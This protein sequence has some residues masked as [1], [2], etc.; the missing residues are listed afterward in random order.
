MTTPPEFSGGGDPVLRIAGILAERK[1]VEG[2]YSR[3]AEAITTAA[4]K[5]QGRGP[6]K[7]AI[8]DRR[9]LKKIVDHHPKV[10]L[11]YRELVA[12]DNYL[13][14]FGQGL[15]R[16]PLFVRP[17]L[18]STLAESPE[19][20]FLLGAKV[21]KREGTDSSHSYLS[22]WDV[23]A[24]REVQ[25]EINSVGTGARIDFEDVLLQRSKKR[26]MEAVRDARTSYF[27]DSGP[28]LVGVGAPRANHAT[29]AM[30]AEM[31]G[32]DPLERTGCDENGP[33]FHFVRPRKQGLGVPSAF[34]LNGDDVA[35]LDKA[36]AKRV[37]AAEC[38]AIRIG[39]ELFPAEVVGQK[40]TDTYG[41][42]AAQRRHGGQVWVVLAGLSAPG[43]LVAARCLDSLVANP[44]EPADERP[45]SVLWAIVKAVVR[46]EGLGLRHLVRFRPLGG[47]RYFEPLS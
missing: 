27:G 12:I 16:W 21:E 23:T 11:A 38:W 14:E 47:V 25:L 7:R 9:K 15:A 3:L 1:R 41:V 17:K 43:T 22:R 30:L 32:V 24:L 29:E 2:S 19:I 18:L 6:V 34:A 5:A 4:Q 37:K 28:S 36:L 42:I 46:E 8:I 44:P 39:D 35:H 13:E 10:V 26:A 40:Q 31:F 33:P 45:A 20:T